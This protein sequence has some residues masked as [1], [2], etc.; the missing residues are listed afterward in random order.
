[1]KRGKKIETLHPVVHWRVFNG[2]SGPGVDV[3]VRFF[4]ERAPP[5]ILVRLRPT[6]IMRAKYYAS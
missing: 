5:C 3:R 1:M 4:G 6:P 2:Q